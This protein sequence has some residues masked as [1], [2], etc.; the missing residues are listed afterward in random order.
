[1]VAKFLKVFYILAYFFEFPVNKPKK[2]TACFEIASCAFD[3]FA[4][5]R[6]IY[7]RMPQIMIPTAYGMAVR[8]AISAGA[9]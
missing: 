7:A 8:N 3:Y 6:N 4:F 9:L 5:L 1:M 2:G